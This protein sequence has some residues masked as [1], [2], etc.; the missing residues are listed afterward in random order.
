M[1]NKQH[2]MH[3]MYIKMPLVMKGRW[4]RGRKK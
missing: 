1:K 3:G 4:G 2:K